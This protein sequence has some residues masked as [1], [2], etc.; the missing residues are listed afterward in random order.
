MNLVYIATHGLHDTTLLGWSKGIGM[1]RVTKVAVWDGSAR[2]KSGGARFVRVTP[3]CAKATEDAAIQG[4]SVR[5]RDFSVEYPLNRS[6][7]RK[8]SPSPS[9]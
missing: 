1:E 8:V 9:C 7:I 2:P 5:F 4:V 3:S 6:F